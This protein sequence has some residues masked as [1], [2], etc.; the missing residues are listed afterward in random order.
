MT[1][2]RDSFHKGSVY[3]DFLF[4]DLHEQLN[5]GTIFAA[6]HNNNNNNNNVHISDQALDAFIRLY[7][8]G[9]N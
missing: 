8:K 9:L 1:D 3:T 7:Q 4:E 6:G 5:L 2:L